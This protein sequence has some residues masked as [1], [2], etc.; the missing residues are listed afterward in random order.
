MGGM[1]MGELI[2]EIYEIMNIIM[3]YLFTSNKIL[4]Y[5]NIR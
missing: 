2:Y 5:Y 3:I 4:D 1:K